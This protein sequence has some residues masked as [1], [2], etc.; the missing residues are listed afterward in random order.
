MND[1]TPHPS[2]ALLLH[3]LEQAVAWLDL[4]GRVC[5][6]NPALATLLG[7]RAG[8][9]AGRAWRGLV[10]ADSLARW[11]AAFERACR[12]EAG[13]C[14]CSVQGLDGRSLAVEVSLRPVTG[15]S[16]G[17]EGVA[18]SVS[19]PLRRRGDDDMLRWIARATAPLTGGDFFATLMHHLAEAFGL[20]RGFIGECMDMPITRVRTL[21]YWFDAAMRPNIEFAVAGT[22]CEK[23]L[24]DGRLVCIPEGLGNNFPGARRLDLDGYIGAPIHDTA[25]QRVIGHVVFET[26][27]RIDPGILDNPLFQIFVSRASAELRRKRAEDVLRASEEKYRL[28]VEHQT[29]VVVKYDSAQRLQF[30]SPSFCRLFGVDEAVLIGQSFRPDVADEDHG[31]F[32]AAWE[33]LPAPPHEARF[34]EL[35][36]TAQGWRCIGWSQTAMFDADGRMD[37]VLAVGRDVTER[38]RA[39]EQG[40]QHLQ[41]LAHVGRVSAMGEMASAIAHEINQPL[42]AVRTYAQASR[43]LL[44]RGAQPAE[45]SDTLER[46]AAQAERAAEIIRRLRSFM[47]KE[48]VRAAP[49]A[50]NFIVSEVADLCRSEA[51]QCS[52]Q[53]QLDLAEGL[54][55]VQVDCIQ[56]EQIVLNLVRNGIEAMQQ[57]PPPAARVLTVSTRRVHSD[58]V[59]SVRDTGPGIPPECVERVFDAFFTTK[60]GGMGVG[61]AISRSIAQAHGGRLWLDDQPAGGAMFCLA[62]PLEVEKEEP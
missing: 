43:R 5:I 39:Q 44:A 35:V 20:R 10:A 24:R 56:V 41:Q 34:E 16:G 53:L 30:V 15:S 28:L 60:P 58:V 59:M 23:A 47:A 2:H 13:S 25:G 3:T 1:P 14:A 33:A 6:A 40:R 54:P 12:G 31:R 38:L 36:F 51:S 46:V 55:R 21:A 52:V 26:Q 11:D 45:L 8:T 18:L 32:Q 37:A 19:Q 42:T 49:V 62:L 4:D 22:P 57:L 48:E 7:D 27:G 9:L 50:P 17:I 61:L 29:D